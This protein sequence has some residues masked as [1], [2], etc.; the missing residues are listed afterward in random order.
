M[1]CYGAIHGATD[2]G[3]PSPADD[4]IYRHAIPR[5]RALLD[6]KRIRATFFV[7]A[8][9]LADPAYARTI[10]ALA[11]DGHEIA[12]HSLDHPYDLVRLGRDAM[13][14]QVERGAGAIEEAVGRRPAGFRAPGYTVTDEL[15]DVLAACGVRYDASVFPC[16]AYYAAKV[17]ALA[18]LSAAGRRSASILGSPA[19]LAAPV[20]PY[21]AGRPYTTRG[22]G[23]LE[24][25][26]GVTVGARL[27]FLG[28]A[29]VLAG[30]RGARA[31]AAGMRGR[32]FASLE[33]HGID[34]SDARADGLG[35]L[36]DRQLDLR[37]GLARKTAALEAALDRLVADGRRFGRLDEVD[38]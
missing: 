11:E 28:T 38:V 14:E 37:V 30:P 16:P 27:P 6:A 34:L 18:L 26:V 33:L 35:A 29:L 5:F 12:N 31:I 2:A 3:S 1:R 20:E 15:F 7:V 10:R 21:R 32:R 22:H 19:V 36:A 17:G 24:I 13:T 23:L 25:P 8:R 9:D 4:P